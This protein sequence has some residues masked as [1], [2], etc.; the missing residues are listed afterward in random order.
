MNCSS[1]SF[2]CAL[3]ALA[4][5]AAPPARAATETASP[6]AA[7]SSI[8]ADVLSSMDPKADP[9]QDFYRYACGGWLDKT[10]LPADQA[11]WARSFSVITERNRE[12]IR[13]I[14]EE[15][16]KNPGTDPDRRRI[17]DYYAACMDEAAVAKAGATPLAPHLAEIDKVKDVASLMATAGKL[18]RL[19]ADALFG[20]GVLPDFKQPDLEIAIVIQGGL[21]MPDRDYY[22]SEDTKKKELM[23]S[24]TA[25]VARML[26]LLGESAEKSAADA[27][28]VVAFETELAKASRP[29][30]EMRQIDKLYNRIDLEGLKKL[31]PSLAW[32]SFLGGIGYPGVKPINVATP[33]FLQALEKLATTTPVATLQAY[34][35][36]ALVNAA[37]P[38]LSPQFVDY[39]FDFY[40]H[41]LSGQQENQPRWKRCVSSTTN[42]IGES[43]GKVFVDREFPGDS[44]QVALEMIQDIEHAF[45]GNL[46]QLAWMDDTTRT[47]AKEKATLVAN[48]IGYPDQW[49]DYSAMKIDRVSYFA[50]AMAGQEFEFD[51]QARKIGQPV[52]RKE[53]GMTPQT[54]NAYYNPTQNEIVFPAGILQPPFFRRDFPAAMNYGG[55]G[56]VMGHELT[57]GFDDQGRKFDGT[58]NMREWWAPQVA[59]AFEKQTACVE[60][61]YAA[62]EVEPGVKVQGDLTLGENI[63]DLGGLKEAYVAF[64]TWEARHGN[65]PPSVPGLTN[66]QL[67]FVAFGQV[68]CTV[69]SPEFLRQQVTTDPHSPGRFRAIGPPMNTP[70][71]AEAFH[72]P[73]GTPMH[74]TQQCTVW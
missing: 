73:V 28:A 13:E 61:A 67:L 15:A 26:A 45:E 5:F 40:G 2:A 39:N 32:D 62:F 66:D 30:A 25:H 58:G 18:Q 48:K 35:R 54:V 68:W 42:A 63:A 46:P 51:R 52:D 1:A 9:C 12:I 74:P 41:T 69:A 22:L 4:V 49:R 29:R 17:G 64:K 47:R 11:R 53:W 21:G 24:Y 37:A 57:H 44:K 7:A 31:T 72:C 14:L 36:W 19:G 55:V 65:P 38:Y 59:A 33:E 60:K 3:A 50:N 27:T 20:M 34:L 6:S 71:F 56:A 8:A 43:I 23:K 70:A 16:G 10:T